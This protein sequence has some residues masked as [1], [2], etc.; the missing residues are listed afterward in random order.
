[1]KDLSHTEKK[2][3]LANLFGLEEFNISGSHNHFVQEG[4]KK[5]FPQRLWLV[6]TR[7]F[8]PPFGNHSYQDETRTANY[9]LKERENVYFAMLHTDR[10][11][12]AI[13]WYSNIHNLAEDPDTRDF[14]YPVTVAPDNDFIYHALKNMDLT[15][16]DAGYIN[17]S[18]W[19]ETAVEYYSPQISSYVHYPYNISRDI[20]ST[21]LKKFW[22]S[23]IRTGIYIAEQ[24]EDNRIANQFQPYQTQLYNVD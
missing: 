15:Y 23:V 12:K 3:K 7:L 20:T 1:M 18:Y 22:N 13:L 14:P 5:I 24:Y 17:S 6:T 8:S 10:W 11:S 21:S 19:S 9:G 2:H 16:N 4:D